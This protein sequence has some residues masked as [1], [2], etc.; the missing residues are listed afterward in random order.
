MGI[1]VGTTVKVGFVEDIDCYQQV[2]DSWIRMILK[3][4]VQEVLRANH[5]A[6][7]ASTEERLDSEERVS[8]LARIECAT[9]GFRGVFELASPGPLSNFGAPTTR[10]V[11]GQIKELLNQ[12][13]ARFCCM[14]C[15][16]GVMVAAPTLDAP[17]A[18]EE[19]AQGLEPSW[20]LIYTTTAGSNIEISYQV[21][22]EK[23]PVGDIFNVSLARLA[24]GA[25]FVF[26]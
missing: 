8:L 3:D 26:V 24:P 6:G 21:V 13:V 7:E 23:A 4:A 11:S 10:L 2:E 25:A 19:G 9:P 12:I 18:L 17:Y 22:V 1:T 14:L 15:L 20:T 5:I 16:H